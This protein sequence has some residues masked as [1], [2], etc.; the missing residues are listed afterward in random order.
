MRFIIKNSSTG[1]ERVGILTEFFKKTSAVIETPTA[2]L[3]TQGGSVVHLTAEVLSKVFPK[4]HLLWVPLSNSIHLEHGLKA[5]GEGLAKFAGLQDHFTCVTL[6]NMNEITPSGHF[7]N[8]K[9]PLWTKHGKKMLTADR[10]MDLMEV[11]K[12]DIILAIADGRTSLVEGSKR[13]LKSIERTGNML[14]VC[15]KR[16]KESKELQNSCLIG[17]VVGTGIPKKCDISIE[18]VLNYKDV[19]GGVAL[20]GLTDGSEEFSMD[21]LQPLAEIFQRIGDAI[22][23]ELL[24]IVEGC[25][26]PAVI[27]TAVECGW[28]LFD[29][30]YAVKLAN[31]GHALTL[32]FDVTKDNV[33]P[34]LLDLNDECYKDEFVPILC[35]CEC[36]SCKKH[37]RAYVRH[38]LNTREMLASVLLTIH[39]LHHFDQMFYHAR[40]HINSNTFVVYKKH[41]IKQYELYEKLQVK[42]DSIETVNQN[43]HVKKSRM[44]EVSDYTNS[45]ST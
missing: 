21:Q 33:N 11:F 29:N 34:Y 1:C 18:N 10:Y 38:L 42:S 13:I 6:Q 20:S 32:N 27:L 43:P 16:Y 12:P 17:V 4:P 26:N 41:I 44:N 36:L 31:L 14:H 2:V 25:W 35:G 37:T 3:L 8:D 7:E 28:D 22:P 15:V 19:L 23:K 45:N 9:V 24:H 5:Q 39:N 40:R 30:S